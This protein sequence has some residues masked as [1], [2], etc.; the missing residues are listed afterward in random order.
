MPVQNILA[1]RIFSLRSI[2]S[3]VKPSLLDV[4]F[5]LFENYLIEHDRKET[6]KECSLS[7]CH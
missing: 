5:Q 7:D 3:K 2:L 4:Y 1:L 6:V